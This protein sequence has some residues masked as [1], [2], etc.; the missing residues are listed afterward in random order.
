[1]GEN[2]IPDPIHEPAAEVR[3][4]AGLF[5]AHVT[6]AAGDADTLERF[7]VVCVELGVKPVLIV[8]PRGVVRSQPMANLIR[9]G[10]LSEAHQ[11]ATELASAL[12][13]RG[14]SIVR[15]KIEAAPDNLDIPD[16]DEQAKSHSPGN[17]FEYHAKL[18]L[19]DETALEPIR[20]ACEPH[21]AH[22]SAN[23]FKRTDGGRIERFVTLRVYQAGR[24]EA[25]RRLSDLLRSLEAIGHTPVK[26]VCEYCVYDSNLPLDD[27]WLA[28]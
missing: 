28:P 18:L 10:T 24:R 11:G 4:Y 12:E 15:V 16:T 2:A 8:L 9:R 5:E 1:M 26:V 3:T 21:R 25:D 27:G 19:G 14:F 7:R 13:E 20:Q 6:V 17:Y 22:L 23:A